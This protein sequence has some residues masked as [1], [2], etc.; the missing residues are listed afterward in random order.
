MLQ[1]YQLQLNQ[2]LIQLLGDSGI[3]RKFKIHAGHILRLCLGS[4]K[5]SSEACNY[6][7]YVNNYD[8][9]TATPT[10]I[11]MGVLRQLT[12]SN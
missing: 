1:K 11:N 8:T 3:S 10:Q 9:K 12:S 4:V 7:D 5:M 2:I 6:T